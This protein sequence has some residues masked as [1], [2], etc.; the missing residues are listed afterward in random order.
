MRKIKNNKSLL[1]KKRFEKFQQEEELFLRK[2]S[3]EKGISIMEGLLDSGIVDELK[4]VQ[5]ELDLQE[6]KKR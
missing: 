5:K 3:I 1:D 6:C 4:R 2:M